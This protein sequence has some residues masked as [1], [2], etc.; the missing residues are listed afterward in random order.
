MGPDE[1]LVIRDDVDH[2]ER[3]VI[4]AHHR[5]CSGWIECFE[6][7]LKSLNLGL[8]TIEFEGEVQTPSLVGSRCRGALLTLPT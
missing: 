3:C 7:G 1:H 2:L 8:Q 6:L 4:K 5:C